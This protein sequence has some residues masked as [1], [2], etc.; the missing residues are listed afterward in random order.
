MQ[1][2]FIGSVVH[3]YLR[4]NYVGY[5]GIF[6][7]IIREDFNLGYAAGIEDMLQVIGKSADR[8]LVLDDYFNSRIN[9]VI[10]SCSLGGLIN[11]ELVTKLVNI[12]NDFP[13]LIV[14][15]L[16]LLLQEKVL[17]SPG[18]DSGVLLDHIV[19]LFT[20]S[21]DDFKF[22]PSGHASYPTTTRKHYFTNEFCRLMHSYIDDDCKVLLGLGGHRGLDISMAPFTFTYHCLIDLMHRMYNDKLM[23]RYE[24]DLLINYYRFL[25]VIVSRFN[26]SLKDFDTYIVD[27]L[28]TYNRF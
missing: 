6:S 21:K 8:K 3:D 16:T 11:H 5:V 7:S 19:G 24:A 23:N 15:T 13:Q 2:Y 26:E 18:M 27:K 14:R 22:D 10:N 28:K 9:E 12:F 25:H 17:F 1:D 20:S 4:M